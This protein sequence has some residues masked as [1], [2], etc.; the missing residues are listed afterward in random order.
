M[1]YIEMF[2]KHKRCMVFN[3]FLGKFFKNFLKIMNFFQLV[4]ILTVGI[5]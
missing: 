2:G 5:S 3:V 4:K 1:I